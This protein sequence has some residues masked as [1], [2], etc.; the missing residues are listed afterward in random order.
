MRERPVRMSPRA[1]RWLL[2]AVSQISEVN[3]AAASAILDRL[4]Q[5]SANL[6]RFPAMSVEG[7]L[8]G[9]RG[10]YL[11]PFILTLRVHDDLI[12]IIAIRHARQADARAPR[13]P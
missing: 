5:L 10:L 8:P 1:E 2:N 11:R 6:S 13:E 9:T 7:V 3:P 12:E 4:R